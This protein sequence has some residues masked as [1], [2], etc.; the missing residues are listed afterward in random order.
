MFRT[1]LLALA[2]LLTSC[3]AAAK[4]FD[5]L[6]ALAVIENED[7]L[8]SGFFISPTQVVTAK[9]VVEGGDNFNV[10]D[11]GGSVY[12]IESINRILYTDAA[13]ITLSTPSPVTPATLSCEVPKRLD[14]LIV[15]GAPLGIRDIVVTGTVA[16]FADDEGDGHRM[17]T[18]GVTVMGMSGGPV[19]NTKGKVVGI[20]VEETAYEQNLSIFMAEIN[21]V[22]PLYDIIELCREGPSA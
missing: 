18:A 11:S 15:A 1:C 12:R 14:N 13:I 2:F 9:H 4:P 21:G 19:Y 5:P 3:Q 10:T 7:G 20:T 22:V 6:E 17:M 8:G 16:G